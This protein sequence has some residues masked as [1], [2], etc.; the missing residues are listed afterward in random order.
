MED[1]HNA[2]DTFGGVEGQAF[3]AVYDGHGGRGVVDYLCSH[4]EKNLLIELE[5]AIEHE[6]TVEEAL[7]SAYLIT[8]IQSSKAG[9]LVSGSTAITCLI[10]TDPSGQRSLYTANC[11]DSRAILCKKNGEVK[12]LSVDHKASCEVEMKRIEDA[13]GFILRKR[14]LGILSVSRS[15]GDHSMKKF[16]LARPYIKKV[17]LQEE[18]EFLVLACDGVWDVI[19]DEECAEIIKEA[20]HEKKLEMSALAHYLVHVALDRGSNDNV[21]AIVVVI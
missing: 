9:L 11:G 12:R 18:D 5:H 4:F 13:G 2:V 19:T 3:F 16:V 6:R 15:F 21:S 14:V 17:L 1:G 8:D 7:I 10:Q 20:V